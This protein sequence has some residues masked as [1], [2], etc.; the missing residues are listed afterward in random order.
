MLRLEECMAYLCIAGRADTE[1]TELL[2]SED[3]EG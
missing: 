1:Y 2:A 3:G